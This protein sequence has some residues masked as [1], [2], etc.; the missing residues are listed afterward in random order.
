METVLAEIR[1]LIVDFITHR[2]IFYNLYTD[3]E[4]RV[5]LHPAIRVCVVY[6]ILCFILKSVNV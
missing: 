4:I 5:G 3:I 1:T 2:L 6:F